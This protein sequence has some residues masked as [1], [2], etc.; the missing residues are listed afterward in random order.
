MMFITHVSIALFAGI[1]KIQLIPLPIDKL[2]F[3]A[4]VI[5][6]ALIPDIDTD[7]FIARRLRVRGL[8]W[9]FKHRGF[10]HSILPMIFFMVIVFLFTGNPYYSIAVLIGFGSHLFFDAFTV[11][12][13]A[14]F[15]PSKL[16]LRGKLR[17]G[18]LID[19]G[20]FLVFLVFDVVLILRFF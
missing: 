10:F 12:G 9:F 6:S 1:L 11:K 19:W 4:I 16:K 8:S 20:L 17:T 2:L 5:L 7:S 15:W 13:I 14:F 18:G 3:L